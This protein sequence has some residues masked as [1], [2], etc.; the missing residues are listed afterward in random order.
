[1]NASLN[2]ELRQ[3][4]CPVLDEPLRSLAHQADAAGRPGLTDAMESQGLDLRVQ[5]VAVIPHRKVSEQS[6]GLWDEVV[7]ASSKG[8]FL[9]R[10]LKSRT[11]GQC[12]LRDCEVRRL[13]SADAQGQAQR[14]LRAPESCA[15]PHGLRI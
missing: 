15:Q 9:I 14:L 12:P 3:V 2:C 11:P 7:I 10:R 4:S 1:M 5:S 13:E 8:T 6:D